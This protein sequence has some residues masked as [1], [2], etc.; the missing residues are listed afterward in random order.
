MQGG[1]Q[2]IVKAQRS[3]IGG[4]G[5]VVIYGEDRA[6]F[7]QGQAPAVAAL[8]QAANKT[9]PEGLG[10]KAYFYATLVDTPN[11]TQWRIEGEAPWQDW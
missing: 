4:E 5:S 3:V 7:W 2:Q 1:T 8:V 11:G 6:G 10:L 9:Q